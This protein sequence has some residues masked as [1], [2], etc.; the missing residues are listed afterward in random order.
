MTS[1]GRVVEVV[2]A[3][4]VCAEVLPQK[5]WQCPDSQAQ[6]AGIWSPPL[7]HPP[8]RSRAQ[9]LAVRYQHNVAPREQ[10]LCHIHTRWEEAAAIIPHIQHK[11]AARL[12][13]SRN[14]LY[15][16]QHWS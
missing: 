14:A 5:R 7:F 9:P 4:G 3:K 6:L 1:Y 10:H 13:I 15:G 8:R 2:R 11:P 12:S 16:V